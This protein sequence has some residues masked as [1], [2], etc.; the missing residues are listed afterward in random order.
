MQDLRHLHLVS[1]LNPD[2]KKAFI[3]NCICWYCSF[4]N[5]KAL[6]VNVDE[7]SVA[8]EDVRKKSKYLI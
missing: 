4:T 7:R 2:R 8:A 1:P 3:K 6:I 5:E